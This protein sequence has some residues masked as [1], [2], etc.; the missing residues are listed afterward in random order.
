[1]SASLGINSVNMA[2]SAMGLGAFGLAIGHLVSYVLSSIRLVKL[3][4]FILWNRKT[5]L[6]D[7]IS[8]AKQNYQYPLY[9]VPS[10][11]I[12]NVVHQLPVFVFSAKGDS[13]VVGYYTLCQRLIGLPFALLVNSISSVL[14]E[15]F[16]RE[17]DANGNCVP[18]FLKMSLLLGGISAAITLPLFLV[19]DWFV[20]FFFGPEWAPAAFYLK[21]SLLP[22]SF[23]F[24][25]SPLTYVFLVYKKQSLDLI[26]QIVSFVITGLTFFVTLQGDGGITKAL[27]GYSFAA[28][29]LYVSYYCVSLSVVIA[30]RRE[31]NV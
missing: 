21:W 14:K 5:K 28:T 9:L 2:L 1:M 12:G 8:Y 3:D 11:L 23:R 16:I 17:R 26:M 13:S 25:V 27:I 30:N 6:A 15:R 4:D 24:F 20:P 18:L 22:F 31:K 29:A 7:S 19:A 10:E